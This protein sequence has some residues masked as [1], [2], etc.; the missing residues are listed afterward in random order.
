MQI[1]TER[2]RFSVDPSDREQLSFLMAEDFGLPNPASFADEGYEQEDEEYDLFKGRNMLGAEDEGNTRPLVAWLRECGCTGMEIEASHYI[3][4]VAAVQAG[5]AHEHGSPGWRRALRQRLITNTCAESCKGG[6]APNVQQVIDAVAVPEGVFWRRLESE[7]RQ[8]GARVG[9][10]R[11]LAHIEYPAPGTKAGWGCQQSSRRAFNTGWR[12]TKRSHSSSG[13]KGGPAAAKVPTQVLLVV[14]VGPMCCGHGPCAWPEPARWLRG[15]DGVRTVSRT[16]YEVDGLPSEAV[17]RCNTF[18]EVW[19]P[20]THNLAIF[21]SAGVHEKH[22]ERDSSLKNSQL[23]TTDHLNS[24]K[25]SSRLR[26]VPEGFDPAIFFCGD[27]QPACD[28]QMRYQMPAARQAH[29]V[30]ADSTPQGSQLSEYAQT[31]VTIDWL[32]EA[33][34]SEAASG[35]DTTPEPEGNLDRYDTAAEN[36]ARLHIHDGKPSTFAS[37]QKEDMTPWLR[38]RSDLSIF[39]TGPNSDSDDQLPLLVRSFLGFDAKGH[40][41]S[42]NDAAAAVARGQR[43]AKMQPII[44]LSVFKWEER[45]GWR[46]LLRAFWSEFLA[47]HSGL[48]GQT[49]AIAPRLLIK[50]SYSCVESSLVHT[51]NIGASIDEDNFD[52]GDEHEAKQGREE[53]ELF[54]NRAATDVTDEA[55]ETGRGNFATDIDLRDQSI[56]E[57]SVPLL[58][59][60]GGIDTVCPSGH[61]Q[62]SN[63]DCKA[64]PAGRAPDTQQPNE[65]AVG[66]R[67]HD[68]RDRP[69]LDDITSGDQ[70]QCSATNDLDLTWCIACPYLVLSRHVMLFIS[71]LHH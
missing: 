53:P 57:D 9:Q 70:R 62:T 59:K 37:D 25:R 15:V 50:T 8:C 12:H 16:M 3:A 65:C 10:L 22:V 13:S 1:P 67:L 68:P 6:Y 29:H 28:R 17:S 21:A 38:R 41:P 40:R 19:V 4:V 7:L 49:L 60:N 39:A 63:G 64:C 24:N 31:R 46:Q 23:F 35:F 30:S 54:P 11:A 69:P 36:Q 61:I 18:D 45:K 27:R 33:Q 32:A 44:F 52:A 42:R 20:S 47:D 48:R 66:D 14:H 34:R 71:Q 5:S 58:D 55:G 43:G 51:A 26:A 56:S 2:V